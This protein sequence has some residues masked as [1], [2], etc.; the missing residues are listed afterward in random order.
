MLKWCSYCQQFLGERAPFDKLFLTYGLCPECASKDESFSNAW[1]SHA[2]VLRDI[3]KQLRDAGRRNDLRAAETIIHAAQNAKVR[4]VDILLGIIAPLLYEIGEEWERGRITV[5]EEHRFTEF[6]ENVFQLVATTVTL[7]PEGTGVLLMNAP[8]NTHTLATR[9]LT[10]W[11][12]SKNMQAQ[13]VDMP[14]N[15]RSLAALVEERRPRFILISMALQEQRAG[16]VKFVEQVANLS[17]IVRPRVIVGGYAV[18]LGMLEAIPG[19]ELMADISS[20]TS[21]P[22][23]RP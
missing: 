18:K 22:G 13:L 6:C 17:T 19:A 10:F 15:F 7:G 23:F 12:T 11:L 1:V 8:G 14:S 20:L 16:V 3:Q 21:D 5:L 4:A 2:H 9:L